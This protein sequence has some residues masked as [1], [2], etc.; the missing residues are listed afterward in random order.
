MRNIAAIAQRELNAYFTSP[1]AYVLI[2]F[3]A[4][5]FGYFFYV[6]LAFF[7]QQSAQAGMNPT[8]AMNIN[9]MLVG[10]TLM[11]TTVIMLFLFPLITMRTYA[12][13]KRSGTIELL[14]TSPITDVQIILGKF[15]GAMLLYAAMLAVTTIHIAILFIFGD[16]EWKPIATGY[17]GLLMMGGCFLSLGLFISSLTKNQIVAAM[18]TFAVFLMLWVINWIGTFVGPTTQSVLAHLSLTDHFDDFAKGILD[19]KHVIYYLSFMAFGLFLT[20]KSVDSE[21]WRG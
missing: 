19:T 7:E 10:P 1:I 8:Q 17:L 2:G 6:P 13:E 4:L 5:L 15:L 16:P 21:R 20:A 11:N 14:L 18:A 12:E 3:F 9:Q